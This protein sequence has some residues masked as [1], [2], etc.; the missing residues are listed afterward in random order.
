MNH[1]M[2]L[3]RRNMEKEW[4]YISNKLIAKQV[5]IVSF[6]NN[7][8]DVNVMPSFYDH[9]RNKNTYEFALL[10]IGTEE[11]QDI[12]RRCRLL[13]NISQQMALK[14]IGAMWLTWEQEIDR[15]QPDLLLSTMVDF[16][17]ADILH[18]LL[19]QRNIPF[20]GLGGSILKNQVLCTAI[21]EYNF[22][23]EPDLQTIEKAFLEIMMP[24]FAPTIV[25]REYNFATLLKTKLFWNCRRIFLSVLK[26]LHRDPL[27]PE[28]LIT[29]K[30]GNDYYIRWRDWRVTRYM[31]ANWREKLNKVHFDNRVFVGLQY[32]PEAT[33]DYWVRDIRLS[34][35]ISSLTEIA[36]VLTNKGFTLF[37]KDHPVMF[38]LRRTDIYESLSQIAHVVFVPYEIKSQDMIDLCKTSLTWTGT[39]GI[40]AALAGRCPVTCSTYYRT[41]EDFVPLDRWEDIALLPE[42]INNFQLPDQLTLEKVR[43]RVIQRLCSA[44]IPGHMEW[45]GFD[46]NQTNLTGTHVFIDSLNRYLESRVKQSS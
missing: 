14:M 15:L 19:M 45:L 18:R 31:D 23:T 32:S 35:C 44:C 11:C 2:V 34:N 33:T 27:N 46:P 1:V 30:P 4:K 13:R 26:T 38:G 29:P 10:K 17:A 22:F 25:T 5:T 43:K 42:R 12:I 41:E 28:Y 40:Q 36:K 9:Y 8:C 20:I 21:G 16:Y 7:G 39:I 3:A 24:T 37:V 6:L